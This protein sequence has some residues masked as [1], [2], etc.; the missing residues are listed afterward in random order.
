MR[1]EDPGAAPKVDLP[2]ITQDTLSDSVRADLSDSLWLPTSLPEDT[3]QELYKQRH[4]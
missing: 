1:G 4:H 2:V 3:L